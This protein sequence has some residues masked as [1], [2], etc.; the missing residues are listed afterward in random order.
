[1]SR[2]SIALGLLPVLALA[3]CGGA[4]AQHPVTQFPAHPPATVE[5]AVLPP[6]AGPVDEPARLKGLSGAQVVQVLGIPGF[7][8]RDNPAE[9]WQY[10]ARACTLDL[11]LYDGEGG[12][13]V[14]HF[15]VRSP[16]GLSDRD[17]FDEVLGKDKAAPSS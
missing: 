10:R 13:R 14:A 15:A 9:I 7:R 5:T 11:F 6:L 17:C 8:R 12:P 2:L 1:M 4:P 16:S 3:A